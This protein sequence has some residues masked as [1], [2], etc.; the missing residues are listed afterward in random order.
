MPDSL[1]LLDPD[2]PATG[3]RLALRAR[4][5]AGPIHWECPTLDTHADEAEPWVELRAGRHVLRAR[6]GETGP[7]RETAITV[8]DL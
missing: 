1:F 2:L 7:W 4:G 3:R 8:R 6:D 5:A